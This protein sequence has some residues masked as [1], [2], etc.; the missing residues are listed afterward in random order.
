MTT[1]PLR[2]TQI[3]VVERIRFPDWLRFWESGA[4]MEFVL[5]AMKIP[6]NTGHPVGKNPFKMQ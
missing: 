1:W 2:R 5:N 3:T 6:L 4:A